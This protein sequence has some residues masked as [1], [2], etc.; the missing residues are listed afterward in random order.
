MRPIALGE[1]G[2]R[3]HTP[4]THGPPPQKCAHKRHFCSRNRAKPTLTCLEIMTYA[5]T[6]ACSKNQE[7]CSKKPLESGGRHDRTV[8]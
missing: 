5:S 8:V 2:I 7:A 1:S 6:G 3:N 4:C